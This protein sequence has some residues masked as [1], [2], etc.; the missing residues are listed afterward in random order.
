MS[1][2]RKD[3]DRPP[4]I[5]AE[6]PQRE[7][8]L[9][10]DVGLTG[11]TR[12]S[13]YAAM[14]Q[15]RGVAR[16]L[17]NLRLILTGRAG[18][19]RLLMRMGARSGLV[20]SAYYLLFSQA[21]RREHLA[22]LSGRVRYSAQVHQPQPGSPLL[23]RN[24]HRLEKGLLM[25]P[26]RRVFATDYVS[27][28]VVCFEK[29]LESRGFLTEAD[30]ELRWA[31]DVLQAY[32]DAA[33]RDPRTDTARIRFQELAQR[34][35]ANPTPLVPCKRRSQEP[36]PVTFDR[37]IA[38]ARRRRSVRWFVQG[39]VPRELINRAMKVAA[40]SPSACNRQPFVFR[41][42]DEEE[43][44]RKA[45]SIP[46]GTAG[47][48][49]NIPMLI[50]VVGQLRNYFSERDRH[51]IYIDACLAAMAFALALETLGL[52]SCFINCP[53]TEEFETS[54]AELLTLDSDERPIMCIAVGYAD[55]AGLIANSS[56]KPL[57]QL[58]RYNCE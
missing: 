51:L 43:L 21:F 52:S 56:K 13:T 10:D 26:R 57:N 35:E 9:A 50:V 12:Q 38:L 55:P 1:T 20:A 58:L 45:V 34:F 16:I 49:H 28:T 8:N 42:L 31:H 15:P 46:M 4:S 44:L 29:I 40:Q 17:R 5:P 24:I 30:T 11:G 32:F 19:D 6:Q 47:Y 39:P 7:P 22:V 37:L 2:R 3:A 18:V 54:M 14:R 23:R 53:D 33:E 36:P 41:V 48:G 25:V 27:E